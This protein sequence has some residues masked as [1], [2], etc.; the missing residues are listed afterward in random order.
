VASIIFSFPLNRR[1]VVRERCAQ[2]LEKNRDAFEPFV[3]IEGWLPEHSAFKS[4]F[5]EYIFELRKEDTW[6]GQ[7]THSRIISVPL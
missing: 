4:A 5:D 1:R 6:G 2:H 3:Y 7:V